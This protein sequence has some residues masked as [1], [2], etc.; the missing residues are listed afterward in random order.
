MKWTQLIVCIGFTFAVGGVQSLYAATVDKK[1]DAETKIEKVSLIN[2][3][4]GKKIEKDAYVI[5]GQLFVPCKDSGFFINKH[6]PGKE[7]ETSL[8]KKDKDDP[9]E[10]G[11]PAKPNVHISTTLCNG[12]VPFGEA[13][14]GKFTFKVLAEIDS[15]NTS[16]CAV[17]LSMTDPN[18]VVTDIQSSDKIPPK[19]NNF[20][21]CAPNFEYHFKQPGQYTIGFYI[22][23]KEK[24]QELLVV[25]KVIKV[26][27][28]SS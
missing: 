2:V 10:I 5:N 13:H 24:E 23:Y 12:N 15:L 16:V 18:G 4:N 21:L 17:K 9:I 25:E 11:E 22:K 27:T 8:N 26:I 14:V 20:W 19:K 1:G 6:V 7:L 28:P 3:E